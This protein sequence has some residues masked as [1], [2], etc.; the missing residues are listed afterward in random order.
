[1]TVGV[2]GYQG[3]L[4]IDSQ[5]PITV[6]Y[7]FISE[8]LALDENFIDT[9]GLRGT[10]SRY[11]TSLR[12]GNRKVSGQLK[13]QPTA[14]ELS[15][16]FPWLTAGTVAAGPPQ[17]FALADAL[18][19]GGWWITVDRGL[20]VMTYNG[21]QPDKWT[22]SG[23]AGE[24]LD[25]TID[26]VGIDETIGDSGSFPSTTIDVTTQP[27]IFT[28]LA[29]VVNSVA[30]TTKDFELT[31]DNMI[32][33]ERF[34]NSQ[35]LTA[36]NAMD[37]H[38]TLKCNVPYG[39]FSALYGTGVSGVVATATFTGPGTQ[40]LLFTMSNIAFPRKSPTWTA[41]RAE[42]FL[43]LVGTALRSGSTMEMITSLH[44]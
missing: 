12:Q 39:Q 35:T 5:N 27:F 37:R 41:G 38:V 44:Q 24:P 6:R 31:V 23:R 13:M 10:R 20:K 4:G 11:I 43:P 15:T 1:M 8:S 22:I 9:D 30:C 3:Q 21:C 29:L 2:Y 34:L 28:D 17:T 36:A 32:D 33:K 14:L 7:D 25:L 16:L 42:E 18:L 40:V 26:V 19:T